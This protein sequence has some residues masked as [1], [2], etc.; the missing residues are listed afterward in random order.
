MNMTHMILEGLNFRP[1]GKSTYLSWLILLGTSLIMIMVMAF[2]SATLDIFVAIAMATGLMVTDIYYLTPQGY[3]VKLF[4][5]LLSIISC[6]LWGTT[7]EFYA[8]TKEK[9]K[10]RST[11]SRFVSPDVVNDMLE[12]PEHV[13]I[14]GE[15]REITVFFSD[16]R[17]FTEISAKLNPKVLSQYINRYMGKMTK[18]IFEN[19]GTLDKYIGD[20]IVAF[21]GAPL[22]L[23]HHPY[24]ALK[25]ALK[26]IDII[27]ELNNEYKKEGLPE[28]QHGIGINTGECSVGN[29]GSEKIFSY[30]AIGENMN[31]GSRLEK[32]CK[33]Y[34]IQLHISEFTYNALTEE[35]K[36]EFKIRPMDVLKMAGKDAFFRT[37][38]VLESE[39]P[40]SMDDE[41]LEKFTKAF[42][43][44]QKEENQKAFEFISEV[45]EK[46]PND[47]PTKILYENCKY[48]AKKSST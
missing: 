46:Y 38:Q 42:D 19:H 24:H 3:Q 9:K 40:F 2:Q 36:K 37:F 6:Y 27:P 17:N 14:G 32:L 41:A 16:I 31:L 15:S 12:H 33:H 45:M 21:W 43:L 47:R 28:L 39:H 23:E 10:I 35:Q 20:A 26:M 13:K 4:F 22:N 29:M 48:S 18:I 30:T 1:A 11:F 44:H 25:S 5:C 7:V 8:T 34:G